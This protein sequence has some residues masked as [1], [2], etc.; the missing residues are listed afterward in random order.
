M[1]LEGIMPSEINQREKDKYYMISL[2]CG[3]LKNKINKQNR[4]THRCRKQTNDCQWG[5]GHQVKKGKGL[6]S[7]NWQLQHSHEHVSTGEEIY[8]VIL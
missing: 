5:L 7:T 6:R 3:I 2:I 4:N 8:S 1:D